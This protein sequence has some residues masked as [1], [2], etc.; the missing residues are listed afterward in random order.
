MPK[1]LKG[2]LV[3]HDEPSSDSSNNERF[4]QD[5]IYHIVHGFQAVPMVKST[6][7]SLLI[8]AVNDE[9]AKNDYDIENNHECFKLLRGVF[10]WDTDGW[11]GYWDEW[12]DDGHLDYSFI[13][14][15]DDDN[16]HET[17]RVRGLFHR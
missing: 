1:Y 4:I 16:W 3:R 10:G 12:C 7:R 5:I 8:D 14:T 13:V 2:G 15:I 17:P 11:S 6:Y 9:I